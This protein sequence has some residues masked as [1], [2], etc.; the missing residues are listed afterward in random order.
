MNA[1][2]LNLLRR[3]ALHG[4]GLKQRL[5][6]FGVN[7]SQLVARHGGAVQFIV[8]SGIECQEFGTQTVCEGSA[9]A[10]DDADRVAR[11]VDQH[12]IGTIERGA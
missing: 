10:G 5:D 2:G 8:R 9:G 6:N 1:C 4:G 12:A 7:G 11:K 3:N